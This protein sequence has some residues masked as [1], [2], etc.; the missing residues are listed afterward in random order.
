MA[1]IYRFIVENKMGDTTKSK[2]V[3]GKK[4]PAKS[5]TTTLLKM[6]GSSEKGG[7]EANRKLRAVNPLLNKLTAGY[8]EKGTRIGRAG[9][10]LVKFKKNGQTGKMEFAGLSGTAIAIIIAFIIATITSAQN[11]AIANAQKLNKLNYKSMENGVGSVN[12][13][14]DV[15]INALNGKITYNQNK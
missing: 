12:G 2:G 10:G 13:N 9:L 4:K 7:V 3:G 15:S 8:W 14:F 6:L 5:K 1:T 11:K